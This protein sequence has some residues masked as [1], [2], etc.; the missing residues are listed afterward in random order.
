MV[1]LLCEAPNIREVIAFPWTQQG[2]DLLMQAPGP[3]PLERWKELHLRPWRSAT[4]S[5][6]GFLC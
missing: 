3:L 1:M 5:K 2:K 4:L 6:V